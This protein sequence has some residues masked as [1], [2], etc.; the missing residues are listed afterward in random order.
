MR[1]IQ[2]RQLLRG[3]RAVPSLSLEAI[4]IGFPGEPMDGRGMKWSGYREMRRCWTS[5]MLSM[6]LVTKIA[7]SLPMN[8]PDTATKAPDDALEEEHRLMEAV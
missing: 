8:V 6:A 5:R 3:N 4:V 7:A 2:E 1:S